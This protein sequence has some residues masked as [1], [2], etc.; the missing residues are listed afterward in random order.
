M[1]F[2]LVVFLFCAGCTSS[3]ELG[4]DCTCATDPSTCACCTLDAAP[5]SANAYLTPQAFL[6]NGGSWRVRLAREASINMHEFFSLDV[7]VDSVFDAGVPA[8]GVTVR[9]DARMPHHRHGML[10]PCE[11]TQVA[12]GHWK[13]SGMRLHM[14]GYW[15]FHVDIDDAGLVER[16]QTSIELE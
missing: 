4:A 3:S 15:E 16:A 10:T 11:V 6:S 7:M 9:V 12:P 5:A 2:L 1:R 14:V 13:A 8:D